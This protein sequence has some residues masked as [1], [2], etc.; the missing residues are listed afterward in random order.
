[1][2]RAVNAMKVHSGY[3][4]KVPGLLAKFDTSTAF[5]GNREQLAS[6]TATC[7]RA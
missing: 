4:E 1:M 3:L 2:K 6:I 7:C 5:L